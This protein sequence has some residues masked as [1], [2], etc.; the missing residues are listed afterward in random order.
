[1]N[2]P[3][4]S[5][6]CAHNA[7]KKFCRD[8][9]RSMTY[10]IH[11]LAKSALGIPLATRTLRK[12]EFWAVRDT[13]FEIKRGETLGV[14]GAN[15]SGKTTL[16]RMLAGILPPDDGE[17]AIR[18]RVGALISLGAG[19]H[20]HMTGRENIYLNGAIIGM[21]RRDIDRLYDEIVAFSELWDFMESP[22]G[23]Y[24]S[25]MRVRLGFAIAIA[26]APDVLLVDEVLAVGDFMFREK[27]Y[28]KINA[29]SRNAG[30]VL[31]SHG[32][33]DITML[34]SKVIVMHKGSVAF[35]GPTDEAVDFYLKMSHS[36]RT[37]TAEENVLQCGDSYRDDT[38][39][40]GMT[41]RVLDASGA[42][43]ETFDHGGELH[44]DFSF[45]VH[46]PVQNL[47]IGMPFWKY[48]A[49]V[50]AVNTDVDRV[51][52]F[53]SP[54]GTVRGRLTVDHLSFSPGTYAIAI[55]V[56]DGREYL[57]RG[58]AGKFEIRDVVASFGPFTPAHHWTVGP[59]LPPER[60]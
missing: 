8:L 3:D 56:H 33:R 11:D 25:G 43:A 5:V 47:I 1:M 19:F 26:M 42:P 9:R 54:D 30:V 35:A 41:C 39:L 15:G 49:A 4:N 48:G 18:G 27:C 59:A 28:Q 14:I 36:E 46:R 23:T 57:Y 51:K 58:Y 53:P 12:D 24:S 13:N 55:A 31:V 52:L 38:K 29:I 50:T 10:G 22:L 7:G 17:I 16:L 6:A 21:S 20:P 45:K 2:F 40:T 60:K 44:V 37:P 34:A 32:M